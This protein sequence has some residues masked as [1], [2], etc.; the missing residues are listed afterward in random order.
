MS[1]DD[2]LVLDTN[3]VAGDLE[4]LLGFD[5]TG[6]RH[7]CAHCGNQG[8]MGGLRAWTGGPGVVLRCGVCSNV[9]L[10]WARTAGG[11]RLDLS[12]VAFLEFTPA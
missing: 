10:R 7:R 9:V 1:I 4:E 3:A 5:V 6:M 11:V 8:L 12:G 2:P